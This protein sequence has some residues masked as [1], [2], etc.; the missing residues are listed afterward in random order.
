MESD[1]FKN[2]DDASLQVLA[3]NLK[4]EYSVLKWLQD[5][6]KDIDPVT[7][8][9][10]AEEK[11]ETICVFKEN[12]ADSEISNEDY[13]TLFYDIEVTSEEKISKAELI[14]DIDFA[15]RVNSVYFND[16]M[17]KLIKGEEPT[18]AEYAMMFIGLVS[19]S[20]VTNYAVLMDFIVEEN[21]ASNIDIIY[22]YKL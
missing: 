15:R 11:W 13:A 21:F 7:N 14:E 19:I 22:N 18:N 9:T 16:V 6:A 8:T 2:L 5:N 20:E 12:H 3:T 1:D 17:D 10:K 4:V